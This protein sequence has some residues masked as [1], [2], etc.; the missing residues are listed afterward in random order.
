MENILLSSRGTPR[1]DAQ[2]STR[3]PPFFAQGVH[4]VETIVQ[5]MF[6]SFHLD[7]PF[8]QCD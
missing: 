3:G 4:I 8:K 2:V 1:V 5:P 6:I 7:N